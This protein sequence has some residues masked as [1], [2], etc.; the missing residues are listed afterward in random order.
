MTKPFLGEEEEQAILEV[1]KS[2]W[3]TKGPKVPE[4]EQAFANYIGTRHAI[5]VSSGTAALHLAFLA[6][7]IPPDA[8]IITTP[9]TFVATINMIK[10]VG[11]KPVFVDIRPDTFNINEN[12]IEAAITK[13][14]DAIVPVHLFGM[15]CNM[16]KIMDIASRHKLIV[17]EDACQ[18]HGAFWNH[19]RIG[20]FGNAACFS[21]YPS[22]NMTTG[23][24][25]IV[26]TNSDYIACMIRDLRDHKGG[27]IAYNYRMT[28]MQAVIGIEQ[29]KKLPRFNLER[30]GNAAYL[31]DRLNDH[32]ACPDIAD[33][34]VFNQFTIRVK[35]RDQLAI[36]LQGSGID[37]KVYYRQPLEIGHFEADKASGE[38]LSLPVYPSLGTENMDKII[39]AIR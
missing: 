25:G 6:C 13:Q 18:A 17:I 11:A 8:E 2:G 12:K 28:E 20:S 7:D 21:F 37:T 35:N 29:L 5:A 26:T 34:H 39:K 1:L 16:D 30:Q 9:F 31:Y 19:R 4:F 10:A 22:K 27:R 24:G 33:G 14:T 3:L 38:V 23:E 36:K 15:P 32:V